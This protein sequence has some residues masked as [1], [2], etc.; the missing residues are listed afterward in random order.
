MNLDR[1]LRQAGQSPA[2]GGWQER[3]S[4]ATRAEHV[5]DVARDFC[6]M[7]TPEEASQLPA[8]CRPGKLVDAQDVSDYA[9]VLVRL[10]C[11]DEH[12]TNPILLK[13]AT[14]FTRA[15]LRLSQIT[16]DLAASRE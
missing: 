5:V 13:L 2:T 1:A 4:A 3:L 9:Y 11:A 16:A 6:A 10:S 14:F 8:D 12:L 15:S 7:I